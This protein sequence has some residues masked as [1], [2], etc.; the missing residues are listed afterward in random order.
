MDNLSV[1]INPDLSRH[2]SVGANFYEQLF[3]RRPNL[4]GQ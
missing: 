2:E 1:E 3:N 4:I